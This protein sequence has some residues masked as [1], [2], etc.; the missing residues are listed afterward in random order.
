MILPHTLPAGQH[1]ML[2]EITYQRNQQH[3][4]SSHGGDGGDD[5][6]PPHLADESDADVDNRATA[7]QMN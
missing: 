1:T 4:H 3:H 5:D 7:S 2:A 6:D